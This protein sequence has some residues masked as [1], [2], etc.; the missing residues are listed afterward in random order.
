MLPIIRLEVGWRT[1]SLLVAIV[2]FVDELNMFGVAVVN[3]D[4][5]GLFA[6]IKEVKVVRA[7]LFMV[8]A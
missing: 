2:F 6:T 1:E 8:F 3:A 4:A 5:G 7:I